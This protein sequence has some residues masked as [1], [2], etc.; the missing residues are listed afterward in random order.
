MRTHK[1]LFASYEL[2]LLAKKKGFDEPCLIYD[3]H[4]PDS[5]PSGL[6]FNGRTNTELKEDGYHKDWITI[7]LYQQL[8]DWFR[9]KH[10]IQILQGMPI[11]KEAVAAANGKL[12]HISQNF[13]FYI[14]NEYANP[15]VVG[16]EH[17]SDDYYEALNKAIEKAF[18]LI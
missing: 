9:V 12:D 15:R 13:V 6:S 14:Y 3:C 1:E 10:N 8:I 16:K 7:P 11:P 18:K 17:R 4:E 2:A 5:H